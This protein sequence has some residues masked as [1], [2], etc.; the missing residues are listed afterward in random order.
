M[1]LLDIIDVPHP[2][3]TKVAKEVKPEEI[4]DDLR[5]FLQDMIETMLDAPGVGLAAPQVDVSKRILVADASSEDP[6]Q[7]PF[8]LI[9]PKIVEKS[10]ECTFEEGCLSI[11]EFRADIKRSK[12]VKVEYLDENGKKQVIEDDGFLAIIL[13]H[14]IDH[15]NG[16]TMLDHVS[17]MKRMMYLKKLKK[18]KKREEVEA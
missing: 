9:N 2:T 17:G 15:L 5:Q 12:W 16:I 11:P 6:N 3:L 1:A 18:I 10:G 8:A 13:Q 7:K 14:E 4:N